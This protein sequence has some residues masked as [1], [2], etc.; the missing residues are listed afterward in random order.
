[1]NNDIYPR[2]TQVNIIDENYKYSGVLELP[3]IAHI[4]ILIDAKIGKEYGVF[5][6]WPCSLPSGTEFVDK[7][8]FVS[9]SF[10][11]NVSPYIE[12]LILVKTNAFSLLSSHLRLHYKMNRPSGS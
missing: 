6:F 4:E 9:T 11:L 10:D 5:K 3:Q 12:S 1:M 7:I 8:K 2:L